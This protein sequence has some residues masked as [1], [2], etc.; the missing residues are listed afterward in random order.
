MAQ[1]SDLRASIQDTPSSA[2]ESSIQRDIHYFESVNWC[3]VLTL[4][5]LPKLQSS[6]R[7]LESLTLELPNRGAIEKEG[8]VEQVALPVS[9]FEHG[10]RLPFICP[11]RDILHLLKLA[12]V[13]L[14]SHTL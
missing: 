10:L 13:Q 14:H 6:Y 8:F 4:I 2:P 5:D 1:Q 3:F 12:P 11:I 9:A 7:I